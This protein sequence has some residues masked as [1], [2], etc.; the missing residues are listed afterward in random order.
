MVINALRPAKR[1]CGIS[2]PMTARRR[3]AIAI[4]LCG[5]ILL[6]FVLTAWHASFDKSPTVDEPGSLV[7][8]WVQLHFHDW[9]E[10]CEYPPLWQTAVAIGFPSK[11]YSVD[12][13]S[14][15]WKSLLRNSDAA[16]PIGVDAYYHSPGV[17]SDAIMRFAQLRMTL[18]GAVMGIVVAWWAWRLAGPVAG[19]CALAALCLDPTVLGHSPLIKNDVMLALTCTLVMVS[20]WLFGERATI[21]RLVCVYLFLGCTIMTKFNGVVAIAALGLALLARSLIPRAWPVGRFNLA[22][23]PRRILF[24]AGV[25]LGSLVFAWVFTWACYDF[26]FLPAPDSSDQYDFQPALQT[27]ARHEAFAASPDPFHL[28]PGYLEDFVRSWR[29]PGSVRLL[30]FANAHRL[31]PQTCLIGLLRSDAFA[32]AR[33]AYLCGKSSVTGW[34]Y[35]FPLAFLF[36]T[37]VSTLIGLLLAS[38]LFIPR[39]R[40]LKAADAWPLCAAIVFPAVY[41][42]VAMMSGVNVGIRHILPVYPFLFVFLGVAASAAWNFAKGRGFLIVCLLLGGLLAETATAYPNYIQFFNFICGGPRGGIR[43]LSDSNLDWG[44]DLPA[45]A[46]WQAEHQDR[47]IYL[48]YWG[49]SDPRHYGISYVNLPGSTAPPDLASPGPGRPVYA[50]G[51]AILT[52]RF[53]RQAQPQFMQPLLRKQPIAVLNGS[54]YIY[55]AP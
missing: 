12:R 52:N 9:R 34:W 37:P 7:A 41:L 18:L 10:D 5:L 22:T 42:L 19:V 38:V 33:E 29:P 13:H 26:R 47:P 17:D 1:I 32:A 2:A 45:L 36:K 30:L 3:S 43:F 24:S 44:Q 21:L 11:L 15:A 48:L 28:R 54:I 49:S 31:L 46:A 50:I 55:D 40:R 39:L 25:F 4:I 16:A 35:Y 27:L 14:P 8:A 20:V 6:A 23:F 53:E 51:A